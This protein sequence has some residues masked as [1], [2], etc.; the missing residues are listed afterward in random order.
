MTS[1]PDVSASPSD[2]NLDPEREPRGWLR[3]L[4]R[5]DAVFGRIDRGFLVLAMVACALLP[6]LDFILR[7]MSLP[8][9]PWLIRVPK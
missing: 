3:L 2:Y 6:A 5:L 4:L 8:T 9:S 7:I 1:K